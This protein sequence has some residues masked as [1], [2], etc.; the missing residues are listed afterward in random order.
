MFG[1]RKLSGKI[2][3]L[4]CLVTAAQYA[5][6]QTDSFGAQ[7]RISE[8]PAR[9]DVWSGPIWDDA[10]SPGVPVGNQCIPGDFNGDGRTD[11][12]CY[13]GSNGD[14]HMGL[15]AGS[16]W[17]APGWTN[18]PSPGIP[19][20]DQCIPS[21]FTQDGKTDV[22][23]FTGSSGDWHMGLSTGSGWR[24][25]GWIG[26]PSP[27]IPVGDQCF[28]GLFNDDGRADIACYIGPEGQWQMG[29]SIGPAITR[30][31]VVNA[32]SFLEGPVAP[33]GIVSIFGT[34][35]GPLEGVGATLDAEGLVN[36]AVSETRVFFGE[37][38]APLFSFKAGRS[39]YRFHTR[40]RTTC[41]SEF[42]LK[43]TEID[44]ARS[45]SQ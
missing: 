28:P 27:A 20:T 39:I 5:S 33:G 43:T 38:P 22:A 15:S 31:G 19:V 1:I 45:R 14:W 37:V 25:P 21:E 44:R 36:T 24:A 29:L 16:G 2:V 4:Y 17:D 6:G 12:A 34:E 35:L 32:A 9:R 40:L 13:T 41:L 30:A 7:E 3:G 8:G 11:L 26:G 18:A 10:P 23:C 42:V